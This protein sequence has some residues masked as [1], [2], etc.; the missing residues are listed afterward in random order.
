VKYIKIKGKLF[1]KFQVNLFGNLSTNLEKYINKTI[2]PPIKIKKVIK[3]ISLLL[4]NIDN[5]I[6]ENIIAIINT[7]PI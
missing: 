6:I 1:M 3:E 4:A 7:L 2:N 5:G